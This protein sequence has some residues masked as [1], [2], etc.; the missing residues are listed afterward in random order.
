[1]YENKRKTEKTEEKIETTESKSAK[2][3]MKN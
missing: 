1:M 3:D 2:R